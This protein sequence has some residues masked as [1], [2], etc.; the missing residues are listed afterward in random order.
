MRAVVSAVVVAAAMLV[1]T[2]ATGLGEPLAAARPSPAASEAARRFA[3]LGTAK[4]S[5]DA[6]PSPR[7]AQSLPVVRTRS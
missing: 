4:D 3:E 2:L 7:S 5:L 6:R 1:A